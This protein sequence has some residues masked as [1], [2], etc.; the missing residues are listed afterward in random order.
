LAA[1]ASPSLAP[2]LWF[3]PSA[4]DTT[5]LG[6]PFQATR[7]K[8]QKVASSG[9]DQHT[10]IWDLE[11]LKP[12][13]SISE[14]TTYVPALAFTPD[15]LL[16]AAA[17]DADVTSTRSRFGGIASFGSPKGGS[18]VKVFDAHSGKLRAE[19]RGH[20]A[21]VTCLSLSPDGKIMA[22]A[23]GADRNVKLWDT[24]TWQELATLQQPCS[25]STDAVAFSPTDPLLATAH[26]DGSIRLWNT[27][28]LRQMNV[29]V[30]HTAGAT[31]L[32]FS[33]DGTR[34]VS[35]GRD[36]T[37]RIWSLAN[38]TELGKLSCGDEVLC[39]AFSPDGCWFAAGEYANGLVSVYGSGDA[40]VWNARTFR[41]H[42]T[43]TGHCKG[44]CCL[45]FSSNGNRLATGDAAGIIRLW[46]L[47]P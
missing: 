32:A 35:G 17:S 41:L 40:R 3:S 18:K 22:T 10:Y 36:L 11:D 16:L 38:G 1:Q 5:L 21:S 45:A 19:L 12:R 39:V 14:F 24:T 26:L 44:A 42:A 2:L 29:L 7:S 28:T 20:L 9:D 25:I 23:G 46:D 47:R 27:N 33:P 34:L 15:G 13:V 31:S 6:F 37:V 30:G 43:L 8:S 4:G